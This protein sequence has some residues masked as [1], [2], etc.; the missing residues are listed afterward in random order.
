MN[1]IALAFIGRWSLFGVCFD[2]WPHHTKDAVLLS[3]TTAF[4]IRFI[5]LCILSAFLTNGLILSTFGGGVTV[6]FV[7]WS[8]PLAWYAGWINWYIGNLSKSI[9]ARAV[10]GLLFG[11]MIAL[12]VLILLLAARDYP[13]GS[14]IAAALALLFLSTPLT[15]WMV[16]RGSVRLNGA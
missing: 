4:F 11:G 1:E 6:L 7:T 9:G 14:V 12:P 5:A 10:L 8:V 2:G 16:R 15:A 13:L 3:A